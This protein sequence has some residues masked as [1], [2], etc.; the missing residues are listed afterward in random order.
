MNGNPAVPQEVLEL[1][2]Q[3]SAQG[4][5]RA[6]R[7]LLRS[8]ERYQDEAP[9]WNALLGYADYKLG[10]AADASTHLRRAIELD[11][12][13][14]EYYMK[15]GEMLVRYNSDDA[16]IQLFQAGL[17]RLPDSALLHFGLAV[18][19]WA[20]ARNPEAAAQS[21][22]EALR[23]DPNLQPALSLLCEILYRQ[24]KWAELQNVA[25]RATKLKS[26]ASLGYYYEALVLIEG[27]A[28][29]NEEKRLDQ[30]KGL[31]N[32]SLQLNPDYSDPHVALG[33]LLLKRGEVIPSIAEFQRATVISPDVPDA[34]YLLATA[35][36]KVG[37]KDKS[38]Q[39]LVKFQHLMAERP[40]SYEVLFKVVK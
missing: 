28:A 21:L 31:L 22:T 38:T 16:A 30:A 18:S 37:E 6:A 4:D 1:A 27:P 40:N 9:E 3:A 13:Q 5:Y 32:R 29:G 11:P 14:E 26:G 7:V 15:M 39:A 17:A 10:E 8:T 23:L 20:H 2:R 24:K 34:Y 36:R 12:T 25:E 35:Y 19:C 33:K